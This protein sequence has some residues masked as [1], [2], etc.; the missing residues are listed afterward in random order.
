MSFF[1]DPIGNISGGI[2]DLGKSTLGKMA[3]TAAL[4]Y[5]LGP[6]ALEGGALAGMSTAG[7]AGLAGGTVSLLNGGNLMDAVKSGAMAYGAGSLMGGDASAGSPSNVPVAE[8]NPIPASSVEKGFGP[9]ALV[10]KNVA[11]LTSATPQF[12]DASDTL[13]NP[14]GSNLATATP[15]QAPIQL[16]DFKCER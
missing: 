1:A 3:E 7:L 10:P 13:A 8:G 9:D 16:I 4:T 6:L 11:N 12:F 2:H 14:V 5:F 15:M